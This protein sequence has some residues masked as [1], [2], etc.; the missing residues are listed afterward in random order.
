MWVGI[1]EPHYRGVDAGLCVDA[2]GKAG[3]QRA[4]ASGSD[5]EDFEF[6]AGADA[7]RMGP[8]GERTV[9]LGGDICLHH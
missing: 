8:T 5:V 1:C 4:I 9:L 7:F 6:G 3:S 2:L